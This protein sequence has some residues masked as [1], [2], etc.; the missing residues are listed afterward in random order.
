[1]LKPLNN[2]GENSYNLIICD[3]I[4]DEPQIRS[5]PTYE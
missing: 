1:M 2:V 4:E 5:N 3:R